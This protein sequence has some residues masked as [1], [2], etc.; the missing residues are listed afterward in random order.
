[1]CPEGTGSAASILITAY[2]R[3]CGAA[4]SRV[5]VRAV[6]RSQ[7]GSARRLERKVTRGHAEKHVLAACILMLNLVIPLDPET[8]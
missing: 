3:P 4:P 6:V 8:W 5:R 7:F 2:M 1:M